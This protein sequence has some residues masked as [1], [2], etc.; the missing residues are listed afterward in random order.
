MRARRIFAGC[1][2]LLAPED[3]K[4]VTQLDKVTNPPFTLAKSSGVGALQFSFAQYKAGIPPNITVDNLE[5]FLGELVRNHGLNKGFDRVVV[6][7]SSLLLAE[8]FI[9]EQDFIRVWYCSDRAHI[10]LATYVCS[11]D[12]LGPELT[13]CEGI[14]NTITFS[15]AE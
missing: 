11:K 12:R 7:S 1:I 13:E 4:Q 2:A 5:G 6:D 9:M 15:G 3:W 10:V 8:S 14:V